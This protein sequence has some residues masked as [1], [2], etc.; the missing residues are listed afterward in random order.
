MAHAPGGT[1]AAADRKTVDRLSAAAGWCVLLCTLLEELAGALQASLY[2]RRARAVGQ[3]KLID[4]FVLFDRAAVVI[5]LLG[6]DGSIVQ[7]PGAAL[8]GHGI[9]RRPRD[10]NLRR[11]GRN[12]DGG[13]DD[14]V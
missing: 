13:F 3:M 14:R 10:L 11:R 8:G 5:A 7:F 9:Q 1:D 4:R 12:G 2:I 6:L